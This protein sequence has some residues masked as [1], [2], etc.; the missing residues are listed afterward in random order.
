MPILDRRK[1]AAYGHALAGHAVALLHISSKYALFPGNP[2]HGE[3]FPFPVMYQE[4]R[5]DS[6]DDLFSGDPILGQRLEEACQAAIACGA[7]TIVGACGSFGYYQ[8]RVAA[9][10]GVPV[11]LSIMMQ[12]PFLQQS[13]GGCSLGIICASKNAL[14]NRIYAECGIVNSE[15]LAIREM[16][17]RTEFDRFLAEDKDIDFDTLEAQTLAAAQEILNE[18]P[19]IGAFVLQ[20]SDLAPFAPKLQEI[21]GLPVYDVATLL[22]WAHS[23]V[24]SP[25]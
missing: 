9:S 25:L 1:F 23:A 24:I 4:V 20:C 6:F 11:F 13:L 3:T 17:G 7:K 5:L 15:S 8:R 16:K 21:Y 10:A 19:N 22:R 14:N 2:Q 18:V 12:V